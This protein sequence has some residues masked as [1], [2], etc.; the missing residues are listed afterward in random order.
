M[1]K[2]ISIVLFLLCT[3]SVLSTQLQAAI[4]SFDP[5]SQSVQLGDT[6]TV[7][8]RISGLGDD[9][10]AAFDIDVSFDDS[11]L[12]YQSF[13]FGTGLDVLGYGSIQDVDDS[14]SGT[15]NVYE[16][17]F[18]FDSDL[19]NLQPNNFVLGTFTFDTLSIG[20]SALDVT[21]VDLVGANYSLLQASVVSGSIS[22]VPV[23]AAIWLFGTALIGM[24][25][26]NKR[27]RDFV[28]SK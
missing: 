13:T 19:I 11:I 16:L 18:D 24:I 23:P 7:D 22:A 15:V 20:T 28:G 4:I 5:S 3:S 21:Y 12:A 10:L 9:I 2:K 26:F 1:I 6:A 25:G 8:L 27:K 17:S 14:V